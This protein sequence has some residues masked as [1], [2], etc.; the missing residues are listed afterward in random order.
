SADSEETD[1]ILSFLKGRQENLKL[2][3]YQKDWPYPQGTYRP[4]DNY[5]SIQNDLPKTYYVGHSRL[6]NTASKERKGQAKQLSAYLAFFDQILS[7]FFSQLHHA[8][9][10][11]SLDKKLKQT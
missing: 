4:F 10:I 8:K 6:P 7:G 11:F 3:S 1:S 9:D 2:N 5:Y